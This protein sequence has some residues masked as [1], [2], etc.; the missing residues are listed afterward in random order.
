M[1]SM[2]SSVKEP[3]C[4]VLDGLIQTSDDGGWYCDAVD[5]HCSV[6]PERLYKEGFDSS[7]KLGHKVC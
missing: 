5:C 4:S 2:S 3:D 6:T 7:T 1:P